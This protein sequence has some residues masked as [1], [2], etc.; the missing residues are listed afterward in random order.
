MKKISF[1]KVGILIKNNYI[2]NR[3]LPLILF[4]VVFALSCIIGAMPV[5]DVENRYEYNVVMDFDSYER[6]TQNMTN[7]YDSLL[8]DESVFS[9]VYIVTALILSLLAVLSLNGFMRDKS[10][11]D[12]YHS[13]AVNRGEL[14]LAN[15]ITA[16]ANT[17]AT[18]ILSQLGGLLLMNFIADYKPMTLGEIILEQLPIIA[19]ILLFTA[20][21][22]ALAMIA[23]IAAGSVFAGIVN[24]I[25][26]NFYAPA[27]ILTVAVSGNQLFSSDLMDWLNHFPHAYAYTSPFI[28]YV[29][30]MGYDM[31]LTVW[32]YILLAVATVLLVVLGIWIYSVKKNE[33]GAKPLPFTKTV[34]PLQY[35]LLFDAILLGA[36]FFEA[37]SGSLIWCII[38]ALLALFFGFIIFN[39]F[40]D[41]SF[42]G[43]FKRSR[44]MAFILIV[45]V[46]LSIVFVADVFH[47]YKEP[48]PNVEKIDYA[49]MHVSEGNA[50]YE[51]W[52]NYSFEKEITEHNEYHAT[53][54]DDSTRKDL[55][56][57]W[58]LIIECQTDRA[59]KTD[60]G[61]EYVSISM[62]LECEGDFS[63]YHAYTN[64]YSSH[65][66]YDKIKQLVDSFEEKY[67][68]YDKHESYYETTEE[69]AY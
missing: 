1:A 54:I 41:K 34:R 43:V 68:S 67:N 4:I 30:A 25:C 52:I 11:N 51:T 33:N 40:A 62:G 13:L 65:P 32:S 6:Y 57:L 19:T 31:E 66:N 50:Q 64:I 10:G 42:N 20:L 59:F 8:G 7:T 61:Y 63:R 55:A 46:L 27:T 9:L 3:S 28:R 29:Y 38:G 44:H 58:T 23:T 39:A 5:S 21:F 26:L 56:E 48:L 24:Y 2:I 37:I 14:F 45:T 18:I 15:Y 36:T 69:V 16:L 12:F 17:A 49:Y 35:M 53:K 47:I 60:S 22:T